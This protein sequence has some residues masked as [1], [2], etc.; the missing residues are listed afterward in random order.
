MVKEIYLKTPKLEELEYRKKLL[1]DLDTMSYNKKHG[2]V[3]DFDESKWA[4]WYDKWINHHNP[5]FFYAYVFDKKTNEPVGEVAYRKEGSE[6]CVMLNIIIDFSKRGN[7]YGNAGLIEL[8][9]IA[10][11]NGYKEARDSINIDSLNSHLLFEKVGFK[12]INEFDGVK[13]YRITLE[14]YI[15]KYGN[16]I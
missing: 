1:M 12:L 13:E 2:G 14:E 9:K 16:L 11:K 7:G 6:D 5:D 3:I 10:F 15:N 4:A 8:I